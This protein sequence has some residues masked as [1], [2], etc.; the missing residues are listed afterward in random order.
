MSRTTTSSRFEYDAYD[1]WIS[2]GS[3]TE[4]AF[5]SGDLGF[6]LSCC[7]NSS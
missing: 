3:L 4:D 6:L 1:F 7:V 5:F 2:W